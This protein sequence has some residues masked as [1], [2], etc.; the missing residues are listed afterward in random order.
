M[1]QDLLLQAGGV[2][3]LTYYIIDL[4][5]PLL[6]DEAKKYL[7][8]ASAMLA[9]ALNFAFNQNDF[10][11]DFLAGVLMW[12]TT[13][14]GHDIKKTLTGQDLPPYSKDDEIDYTVSDE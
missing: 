2:M 5:K 7:P 3:W 11:Q 6:P 4:I 14:K 8:F 12:F 13:S 10:V 9:G 1:V